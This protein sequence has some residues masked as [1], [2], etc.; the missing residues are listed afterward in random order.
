MTKHKNKQK[1]LD[2]HF[3]DEYVKKAQQMGLRSRAVFKLE[4]IDKKDN[5]LR[6]N[7]IVVDLGAAP[8]GW[9]EYAY[10]KVGRRGQ[11]IALDLLD[12]DP[13]EGVS[14]LKGDFSDDG[15]FAELQAMINNEPV[16]LVLSD[17]APNMSG[18]KAIDQPKS[19]YLAELAL[20]FAKNSL[21]K[22]GA[23]LIKLFQG[24]GFDQYVAETRKAFVSVVVRKP[25]ASRARSREVYLLAKGLKIE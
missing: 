21:H 16:D 13:I 6:P 17:I 14:F 10:K 1:W 24:E 7:Q 4:E 9:S 23:F 20:D 25:K 8:G 15:V 12:I 2:E 22:K 3:N 5:L 19:M 18:S 11:V